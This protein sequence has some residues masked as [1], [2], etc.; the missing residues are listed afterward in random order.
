MSSRRSQSVYRKPTQPSAQLLNDKCAVSSH[1]LPSSSYKCRDNNTVVSH[2]LFFWRVK[3]LMKNSIKIHH[4]TVLT[5]KEI[6][7]TYINVFLWGK[8]LN[9]EQRT[10]TTTHW[11]QCVS[12]GETAVYGYNPALFCVLLVSS[13]CL[14]KLIF[15]C[16]KQHCSILLAE[17]NMSVLSI[18]AEK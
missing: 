3:H 11:H 14:A 16:Y 5:I 17:F 10:C 13:W 18:I 7:N 12:G 4:S 9:L 1:Y 2:Q 8:K 15:T 6:F